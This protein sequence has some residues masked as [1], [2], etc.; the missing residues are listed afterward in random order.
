M[1]P[2]DGMPLAESGELEPP[3]GNGCELMLLSAPATRDDSVVPLEVGGVDGEVTAPVVP[4]AGPSAD[5]GQSI[6]RAGD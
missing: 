4:E 1:R 6:V 3:A 2:D 5:A